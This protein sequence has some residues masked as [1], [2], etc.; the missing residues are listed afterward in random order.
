MQ[1]VNDILAIMTS[2]LGMTPNDTIL[3]LSAVVLLVVIAAMGLETVYQTLFGASLGLG[4]YILLAMLFSASSWS[5][6]AFIVPAPL[7][8]AVVGSSLYLPFILAVLIPLN[9]AVRIPTGSNPY[10]KIPVAIL[11]SAATVA[12]FAA[13]FTGLSERIGIFDRENL[14]SLLAKGDWYNWYALTYLHGYAVRWMQ[15][16]VVTGVLAVIYRMLL[17]EIVASIAVSLVSAVMRRRATI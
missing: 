5:E 3:V 12:F 14:F 13:V 9:G 2:F 8:A 17:H 10:V 4:I 15:L 7:A 1:S 6:V 11:L 16:A